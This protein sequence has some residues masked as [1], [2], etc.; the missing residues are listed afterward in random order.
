MSRVR[1]G[2]TLRLRNERR[3]SKGHIKQPA[4]WVIYDAG[5]YHSTGCAPDE[6]DRAQA[7]L[8]EHVANKTRPERKAQDIEHITIADV[9]AIYDD[10]RREKQANKRTFDE[11]LI[12]LNDWWG[13]RMLSHVTGAT[14]RAYVAHRSE[15]NRKRGK[16]V[17]HG[18][19]RRDLEDLRSA[20]NHHAKEGLHRGV[21]RVWLPDKGEPRADWLTR[22]D[23]AKLLS[24]CWRYREQQ[25]RS[26][27]D[28]NAPR[29]PTS[30]HTLRHLAR[31]ILIGLYT[32]SRAATIA[33]AS[34]TR[35][36]GRS[37]VDLERGIF[38][39]RQI[40]KKATNK[41]QPTIPIPERLLAHMRRWHRQK[42]VVSHFVEW[43]G[44]PVASVK[45]AF[46]RA[47]SQAG[48]PASVTPH[49]LRHTAA[50]W[51]MQSGVD[52]WE[53]SGYLGMSVETLQK[54]YGHHHPQY[55]SGAAKGITKRPGGV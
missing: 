43:N 12:R 31:F 16:V 21:V 32:G 45:T 2:A 8:A 25:R 47:V 20:I 52:L 11:R 15:G 38:H 19:A 54:V 22:E 39:R 41:R 13:A 24:V 18:G 55:M 29:L 7:K 9:L 3:D 26:R 37:W 40:G 51:L 35:D 10:D 46:N 34:P 30:R 4:A 48:L 50:T 44:K 6:I 42:L 5:K 49:T 27:S 33:A 28:S 1:V 23:A 17:G 14:C 53:A 36:E